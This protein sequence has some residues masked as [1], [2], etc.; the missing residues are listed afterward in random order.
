MTDTQTITDADILREM[1]R[2]IEEVGPV[3]NGDKMHEY[4][5]DGALVGVCLFGA[6]QLAEMRLG[7]G[8]RSKAANAVADLAQQESRERGWDFILA[9]STNIERGGKEYMLAVVDRALAAAEER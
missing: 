3:K 5:E 9:W 7:V 1:R 2:V 4:N 8:R 6:E